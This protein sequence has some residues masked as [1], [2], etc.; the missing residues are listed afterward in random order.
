MF[1]Y[2]PVRI[3]ANVDGLISYCLSCGWP[4]HKVTRVAAAEGHSCLGLVTL[5]RHILNRGLQIRES[6]A[7]H[8]NDGFDPF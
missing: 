6:G 3:A 1:Y 7:R 4:T 2:L 5:G 8:R